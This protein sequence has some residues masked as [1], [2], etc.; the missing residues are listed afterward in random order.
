MKYRPEIDGLRALAIIPVVLFHAGLTTFSGGFI[1]VDVFFVIS[2]YLITLVILED[3]QADQF[4][5]THFY[6]RRARR[7]LPALFIVILATVPFAWTLMS[8]SEYEGYSKSIIATVLFISNILFWKEDD[9]FA[10]DVDQ[11]PLLHTWSLSIEEQYYVFFPILALLIWRRDTRLFGIALTVIFVS[12]LALA[13]YLSRE[14]ESF[15]FHMLPTRAWELMAGALIAHNEKCGRM[16]KNPSIAGPLTNTGI[17]LVLFS[18]FYFDEHT[19]HPSLITLIPITGTALIILFG[20]YA[21]ITRSVLIHP[22]IVGIGL[23]SYSLYLWHQ[24]IFAFTKL[25][26]KE[27]FEN[28][29]ILL[30]LISFILAY[31]TWKFIETPVRR[32]HVFGKKQLLGMGIGCAIILIGIGAHGDI[33]EGAIQRFPPK[34]AKLIQSQSSGPLKLMAINGKR[35][36]NRP[37]KDACV[38]GERKNKPTW[39]L[40]GD[41]HAGNL[42]YSLDSKLRNMGIAAVHLG[43]YGCVYSPGFNKL[44]KQHNCAQKNAAIREYLLKN[45]FNTIIMAGRYTTQLEGKYYD[46][47]SSKIP[48]AYAPVGQHNLT[49]AQRKNSVK[50]GYYKAILEQLEAGSRVILIYPVPEAPWN[51][52]ERIIRAALRDDTMSTTTLATE[53]KKITANVYRVFDSIKHKNLVRIYPIDIFCN[54]YIKDMCATQ[55][56]NKFLYMDSNHLSLEGAEILVK[57]ILRKVQSH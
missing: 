15:S 48:Q 50:K 37:I 21:S 46:K 36:Q 20:R 6:N 4:T 28:T 22:R 49:E 25:T 35:C 57:E 19:R 31:L 40:V 52:P 3:L 8:A 24:P 10:M 43:I 2:G 23:I 56:E 9:Y 54:T 11:K 17:L 44:N 5:L 53:N 41:S 7:I 12:S 45:K 30:I 32:N 14:M 38:I 51:V 42:A 55:I 18:V 13:E 34:V 47:V 29:Y 1:G 39:A 26:Q 33:T 16:P 27:L